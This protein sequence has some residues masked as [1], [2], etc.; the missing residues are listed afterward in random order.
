MD[1]V[2]N[3]FNRSLVNWLIALFIVAIVLPYIGSVRSWSTIFKVVFMYF[4]VNGGFALAFG[5]AI[6]RKGFRFYWIFAQFLVF[7]LLSNYLFSIVNESY[8]YYLAFLYLILTCFTFFA[9]NDDDLDENE[10]PVDGG[11]QDV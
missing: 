10:L 8:G 1:S 5:Y 2:K 6:R 3:T 9:N 4:I 7:G 11:Y